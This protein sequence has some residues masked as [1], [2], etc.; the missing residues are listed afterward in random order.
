M[1]SVSDLP[2]FMLKE[3]LENSQNKWDIPKEELDKKGYQLALTARR[4]ELMHENA[5]KLRRTPLI[6]E[7]DITQIEKS[8]AT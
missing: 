7:M 3:N 1:S 6:M 4:V 8:V 5:K 2:N